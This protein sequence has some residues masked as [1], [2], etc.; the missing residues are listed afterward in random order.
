MAITMQNYGLTWTDAGGVPRAAAV[1]Y[2]K[3]SAERRKGQLEAGGCT[4]VQLVET[5]PGELPQAK[6]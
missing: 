4:D 3:V 2:D 1:S 5:K 6:S